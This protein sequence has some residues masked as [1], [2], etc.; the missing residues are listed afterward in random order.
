LTQFNRS[1][2]VLIGQP[3]STGVVIRDLRI[4]F[5]V[6]KTE[7]KDPNTAKIDIYNLSLGTRNQIKEVGE[8]VILNAGYTQ[9]DGEEVCFSGTITSITH[10]F[11]R[12]NVITTIEAND[13]QGALGTSKV[14]LSRG[15]GVSARSILTTV[16]NTFPISNNL[17]TVTLTD[18]K[19]ASGFAYTGMSKDALT[20]ITEFLGLSWSIQDNE[21]RLIP[22]DGNDKTRA[23]LLTPNTG[24]INSPQ[25]LTGES[26]KAQKLSKKAKPGWKIESLLSPKI[27]PQGSIGIESEEIPQGSIFNIHSVTHKGDTHGNEWVSQIEVHEK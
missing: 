15:N 21:I 24:L 27:N 2:S 8:L 9:G 14:S 16:L 10:K 11:H 18:K 13:G 17:Q 25:R 20:K 12:P 5:N 3:G 22:F 7:G 1:A 19:Y 4:D 6:E 26:R 23:V